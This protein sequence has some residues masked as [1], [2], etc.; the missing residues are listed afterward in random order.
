MAAPIVDTRN[1]VRVRADHLCTVAAM[2]YTSH[3][4]LVRFQECHMVDGMVAV[5]HDTDVNDE[6]KKSW[7][8]FLFFADD[9]PQNPL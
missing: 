4:M 3:G 5:L 9:T 8:V 7:C 2:T 1:A 6:H